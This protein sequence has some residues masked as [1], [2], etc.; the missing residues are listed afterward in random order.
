MVEI[1]ISSLQMKLNARLKL[2]YEG[3]ERSFIIKNNERISTKHIY[4]AVI[5]YQ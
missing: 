2:I 1:L 3:F 5:T 4:K